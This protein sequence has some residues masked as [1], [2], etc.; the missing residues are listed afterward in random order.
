MEAYGLDLARAGRRE[1]MRIHQRRGIGALISLVL[2]LGVPGLAAAAPP[3]DKAVDSEIV[4]AI[5][6]FDGH[7]NR[8][9]ERAVERLEAHIDESARV[10]SQRALNAMVRMLAGR[11]RSPI[12]A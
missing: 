7:P 12:N 2:T 3:A 8:A 4:H 6:T 1:T 9:S 10:A 5:V 11:T